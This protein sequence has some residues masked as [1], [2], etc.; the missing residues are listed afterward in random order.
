MASPW[1]KRGFISTTHYDLTSAVGAIDR[2]LGLPPITDF[3]RTTR[4]L[5]DLFT[6]SRDTTAFTVD[7]SGVALY[8]FTPLPGRAPL[9]DPAHGVYSFATPDQIDPAL[10][11]AA[12]WHQVRGPPAP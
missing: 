5:D 9:A 11:A 12:T 6:S 10:A 2:I 7:A 8:P 3:A 4:P 1:V